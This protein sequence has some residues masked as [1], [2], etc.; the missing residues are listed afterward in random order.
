VKLFQLPSE[1]LDQSQGYESSRSRLF[2]SKHETVNTTSRLEGLAKE[3][4]VSVLV[5]GELPSRIDPLT[6]DLVP[7]RWET[8]PS[9][10][11][12]ITCR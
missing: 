5:S 10:A 3:L 11:G 2:S 9:G 7:R 6:G 12:I 4:E 8:I 1:S